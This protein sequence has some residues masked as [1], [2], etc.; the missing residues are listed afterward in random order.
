[1]VSPGEKADIQVGDVILKI[2]GE[3]IKEMEDVKPFVKEAG[4]ENKELTLT[5]KRDNE[6]IETTL[7]PAKDEKEGEY[8]IGLYIRDSAAGIGTMTFYDPETKIM[9]HLAM[10]YLI[11]IH[12]SRL[13]SITV[14][15]YAPTL[16]Q[17]KK[18]MTEIQVKNRQNS[19]LKI[20]KIGSI[21]KNSPF[22][23]FGKLNKPIKNGEYDKPM[24]IALS[25]QVKEGP[26][27]ILTVLEGEE[28]EAFDVK[29][30]SSV[31]QKIPGQKRNGHSNN[32]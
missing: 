24:P 5:V 15:S 28:V 13:K 23:I 6:T 21:T 8:R 20:K 3:K 16:L 26:A 11:W 14:P 29:V 12:R 27:K 32:G 4:K 30:V 2:N 17:L 22:G 18:A 25:H 31:P 7:D 9:E 19:P 10:L 1:M